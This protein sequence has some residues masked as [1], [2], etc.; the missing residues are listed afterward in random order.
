MKLGKKIAVGAGMAVFV[1]AASF[2]TPGGMINGERTTPN[3]SV[4]VNP[5]PATG[6]V[7]VVTA[8]PTKS[9]V[10]PSGAVKKSSAE[11]THESVSVSPSTSPSAVRDTSR[12]IAANAQTV[13]VP[14]PKW[15]LIKPSPFPKL[16]PKPRETAKPKPPVPTSYIKGYSYCGSKLSQAQR[17]IDQGK[18]TL[19]YPSGVKTLAGH[20]YKGWYW[21][22]D[23]PNG[24][25]VKIQSGALKGT[26][27]VYGHAKVYDKKFPKSGLGAA[28]ALQ[29]CEDSGIGFSFLRRV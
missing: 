19:Y 24:R 3:D 22:D 9:S 16:T 1:T 18:L 27:K 26:Y 15:T 21:I 20:N 12:V 2:V 11:K 29:T 28:V 8:S 6:T 10:R 4:S 17:C 25:I 5:F 23:L 14:T 7:P 13:K